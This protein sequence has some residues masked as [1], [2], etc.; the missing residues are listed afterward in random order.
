MSWHRV[1]AADKLA[2]RED[3]Q[4]DPTLTD[5]Q[6]RMISTIATSWD[7]ERMHSEC[8]LTFIAAGA[9]T[10]KKMAHKYSSTLTTSGRVS[11]KSLATHTAP[12][13]WDVN[14]WFRG[15]AWVRHNNGGQ[16]SVDCR[17][18][19]PADADEE[20]PRRAQ[21]GVPQAYG[22]ESPKRGTNSSSKEEYTAAPEGAR[23]VGRA[24]GTA[25]EK[26]NPHRTAPGFS[27][28]R[29]VHAEF[30]GADKEIFIAHLRSSKGRKFVLR[31]NIDS[32]EY[33]SLFNAIDLEN[34]SNEAI[35]QLVQMSVDRSSPKE[36]MRAGPLPWFSVTIM[37]GDDT[38]GGAVVRV[39]YDDGQ[40]GRL[41]LTTADAD[42]LAAAC[43][44]RDN[45]VGVRVRCRLMPDDSR[46]F[47][48]SNDALVPANDIGEAAL[49]RFGPS[50][51]GL[52]LTGC[53]HIP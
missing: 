41:F 39:A 18:V 38:D 17:K 34:G 4:S 45:A 44:G 48:L 8:S 32:D 10:T 15:S 51:P 21:E 19:Y 29:I 5:L 13:M 16:P 14:W 23:A 25:E 22:G 9:G 52:G 47:H 24:P 53:A 35:G 6:K 1:R 27:K 2:F 20:S 26:G 7:N 49:A 33:A 36:F 12:T 11:I 3:L 42:R 46:E 40:R 43:G 50:P 28:W 31:C 30:S 37:G